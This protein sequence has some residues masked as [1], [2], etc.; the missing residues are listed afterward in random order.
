MLDRSQVT[1]HFHTTWRVQPGTHHWGDLSCN[2][3]DNIYPPTKHHVFIPPHLAHC[4]QPWAPFLSQFLN[5]FLEDFISSDYI[6]LVW[7]VQLKIYFSLRAAVFDSLSGV[8]HTK[9]HEDCKRPCVPHLTFSSFF[10]LPQIYPSQLL[11]P[12]SI[13]FWRRRS[14][15]KNLKNF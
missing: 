6:T 12:H 9:K 3:T 15:Q 14:E 10:S 5:L 8:T 13:S 2:W 4:M 1:E 7:R 11:W